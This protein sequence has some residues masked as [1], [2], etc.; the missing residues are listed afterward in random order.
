MESNDLF[1]P[2]SYNERKLRLKWGE[3][4]VSVNPVL[5]LLQYRVGPPELREAVFKRPE[6]DGKSLW[7]LHTCPCY[8]CVRIW[9]R[10]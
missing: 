2:V 8:A 6:K 10:L 1:F 3:D 9:L 7:F 5:K 4:A